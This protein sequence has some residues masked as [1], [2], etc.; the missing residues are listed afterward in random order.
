[1]REIPLRLKHLGDMSDGLTVRDTLRLCGD[2]HCAQKI[3]IAS[4]T[5]GLGL[6]PINRLL[7][8]L[9]AS[10]MTYVSAGMEQVVLRDG[11]EILKI[12]MRSSNHPNLGAYTKEGVAELEAINKQCMEAAPEIWTSTDFSSIKT[13]GL[14][15]KLRVAVR[16]PYIQSV[17][18][19]GHSP[20]DLLRHKEVC[21]TQ[22]REFA[23][24]V[25]R[26]V[27][28]VGV[29]PDLGGRD[30]VMYGSSVD[31]SSM[32]P[33]LHI[34]D[35]LPIEGDASYLRKVKNPGDDESFYDRISRLAEAA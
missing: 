30:N 7:W 15:R 27:E 2:R 34:V 25:L 1:M 26:I 23:R 33:R 31:S 4:I 13:K 28:K 10:D 32:T 12:I 29:V 3:A 9:T 19:G 24:S 18:G 6:S 16:Q 35:T 22:A 20:F 11:D 5:H 8:R 14:A 17:A 21:P